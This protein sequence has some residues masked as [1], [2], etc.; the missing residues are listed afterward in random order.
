MNHI[1]LTFVPR[2]PI[3]IK[4]VMIQLVVWR[5]VGGKPL[6]EPIMT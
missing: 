1:S 4:S 2:G 5:Q 6:S 3:E